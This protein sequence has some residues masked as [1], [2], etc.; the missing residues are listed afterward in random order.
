LLF[1]EHGHIDADDS[2]Y[3]RRDDS[4]NEGEYAMNQERKRVTSTFVFEQMSQY[5]LQN[6][7]KI[8]KLFR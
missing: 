4:S 6:R 8:Y 3:Q 5:E 7:S 1:K 2:E